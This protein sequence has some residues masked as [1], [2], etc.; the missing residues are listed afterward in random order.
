MPV[1][2]YTYTKTV[3]VDQLDAEI[4]A[5]A[6]ITDLAYIN[7]LADALEITM[8]DAL[9]GGDETILDGLVTGHTPP[10]PLSALDQAK[11]DAKAL[12]DTAAGQAR[13]RYITVTPG[14]SAVYLRKAQNARAYIDAGNPVIDDV[15]DYAI[16]PYVIAEKKAKGNNHATAAATLDGIAT[17][18][19]QLAAT[20]EEVRIQYKD[21][22]DAAPD[23][24]TVATH[25]YN[26]RVA[27]DNV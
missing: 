18:W 2:S 14:Q 27:L 10:T 19:D 20:M 6:I 13:S 25:K 9:S 17:Q 22:I 21:L 16:Y 7:T 1:T 4:R 3:D 12:I 23:I 24:E 5:S 11:E 15:A 26:G 8:A